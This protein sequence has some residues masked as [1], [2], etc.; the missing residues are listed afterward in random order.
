M[1][2][3]ITY[4]SIILYDIYYYNSKLGSGYNLDKDLSKREDDQLVNVRVTG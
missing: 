1:I 4:T 3:I 2:V